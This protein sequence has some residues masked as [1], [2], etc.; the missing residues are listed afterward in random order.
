MNENENMMEV[1]KNVSVFS[2]DFRFS[3]LIRF[4]YINNSLN[5][6][7]SFGILMEIK[8]LAIVQHRYFYDNKLI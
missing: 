5:I 4:K 2:I 6:D 3:L 8:Y 1:A 7:K